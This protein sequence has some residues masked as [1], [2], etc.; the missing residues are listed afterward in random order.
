MSFSNSSALVT[1]PFF[2]APTKLNYVSSNGTYD[3][4]FSSLLMNGLVFPYQQILPV[5]ARDVLEV[6]PEALGLLVA[7]VFYGVVHMQVWLWHTRR[8]AR[9]A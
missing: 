7:V 9:R 6:G 8:K 3:M 4:K 1:K 2:W 5:F